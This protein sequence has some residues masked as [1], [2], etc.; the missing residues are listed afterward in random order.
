MN[1]LYLLQ[2][3]DFAHSIASYTPQFCQEAVNTIKQ[4][5]SC[6]ITQQDRENA[7]KEKDCEK[8]SHHQN[9]SKATD[10]MY[11]CV[12]NENENK[13]LEVCAPTRYILGF[14]TEFN[15]IGGRIQ[16]HYSA[17]CSTFN[18]PCPGRYI[19]TDAYLYKSCYGLV[20]TSEES[21]VANMTSTTI[22]SNNVTSIH[23]DSTDSILIWLLPVVV[24]SLV[25]ALA[26]VLWICW[27]KR[28]SKRQRMY[29]KDTRNVLPVEIFF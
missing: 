4:V 25:L 28:Q 7:A 11:H 20:E 22:G 5:P 18:P 21:Y 10:F 29:M 9:C 17:E 15:V 1:V 27:K 14:C 26:L 16:D 13:L 2:F 3:L 6:P 24:A 23:G 8:Y 19:S 12:I